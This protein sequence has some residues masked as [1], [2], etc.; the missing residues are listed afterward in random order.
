MFAAVV[1]KVKYVFFC[2]FCFF[3]ILTVF[4]QANRTDTYT[5][6]NTRIKFFF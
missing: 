2:F 5:A 1:L 4:I 6:Y 3:F